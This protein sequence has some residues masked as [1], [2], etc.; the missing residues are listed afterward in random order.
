MSGHD[1]NSDDLTLGE[2][3]A[4]D[5]W[6]SENSGVGQSMRRTGLVAELLQLS[7]ERT[8]RHGGVDLSSQ[9][10]S[11]A[12]TQSPMDTDWPSRH[13]PASVEARTLAEQPEL[14]QTVKFVPGARLTTRYTNLGLLGVGGMGVVL[15]IRD[16]LLNRTLAMKVLHRTLLAHPASVERF[17]QE[18]QVCAQL[19]HPNILPIHDLGVL[20]QGNP[21]MT[22]TEI[23]GDSF[24][25]YIREAHSV[26]TD[27]RWRESRRGW[28]LFRLV[29]VFQDVCKAVSHAHKRQVVHRDLKPQNIMVCDRGEVLVVDWGLAKVL[30]VEET[31]EPVVL[32]GRRGMPT[33]R[34]QLGFPGPL[35]ISHRNFSIPMRW[36]PARSIFMPWGSFFTSCCRPSSLC[37]SE[38]V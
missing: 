10:S 19:Q 30:G 15:R 9:G 12:V 13:G 27:G 2:T 31:M 6:S 33:P 35:R 7:R 22:M 18:A 20:E 4:E 14:D 38:W 37:R 25:E 23:R 5:H 3:L 29:G 28:N 36:R 11:A 8:D 17:I 26:T 21:Y 32:R 34:M 24:D 1:D 16:Q